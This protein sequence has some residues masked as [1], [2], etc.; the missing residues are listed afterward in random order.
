VALTNS[1]EPKDP[2]KVNR[3]GEIEE[4]HGTSGGKGGKGQLGEKAQQEACT[5]CRHPR[6]F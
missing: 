1:G 4:K 2:L 6:S 3:F 5:G